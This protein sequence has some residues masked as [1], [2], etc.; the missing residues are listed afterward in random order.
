MTRLRC[1]FFDLHGTLID[2]REVL[3]EQYR[4]ALGEFM[5]AR[6]GGD[7]AEW[8]AANRRVSEDWDS[9][10]A[11]LDFGGDDSLA[12]MR[13]GQAR[14][15]RALFRLTGR[16]YP[17]PEELTHLIDTHAYAI[18]A[19]CD[20]LYPDARAALAEIGP[21]GLRLGLVTHSWQGHAEGLLIGVG[22]RAGFTGPLVTAEVRGGFAKDEGGYR[23]AARLAECAPEDCAV[24][25]DD[26][27]ALRA[28]ARAGFRTVGVARREPFDAGAAEVI[29]P[30]LTGL[31]DVL[32]AWL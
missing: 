31:P 14:T 28:A 2:A 25:D 3:P 26:P 13:E 15:L 22:L 18:T 7:P 23:L 8:A 4:V 1:L 20:A 19:C 27:G 5:A 16:P 29:L 21:L 10:Y 32:R 6:Y 17:T 30:D 12:Q 11:D 9:Y 24:V